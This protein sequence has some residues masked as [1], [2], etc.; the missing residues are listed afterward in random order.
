MRRLLILNTV[1]DI[2]AVL[3]TKILSFQN[4]YIIPFTQDPIFDKPEKIA[5]LENNTKFGI[6]GFAVS[7]IL[8]PVSCMTHLKYL[9]QQ[10]LVGGYKSVYDSIHS[11][12]VKLGVSAIYWE[13]ISS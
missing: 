4:V 13:E 7:C 2:Y 5:E 12:K 8:Y 9:I 11:L 1:S 6:W 3:N 10:V